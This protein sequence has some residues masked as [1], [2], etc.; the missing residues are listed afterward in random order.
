MERNR[1][2]MNLSQVSCTAIMTLINRVVASDMKNAAFSDPMAA[3]CLGRLTLL[4]SAEERSWILRTKRLL[5]GI[6]AHHVKEVVRRVSFFDSSANQFISNHPGCTVVN[7]G[8]GFDTR[9]WRIKTKS[10]HMLKLTSRSARFE[11]RDPEG[12]AAL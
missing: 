8:C 6:Q 5:T 3:L 4:A 9:F 11:T 1:S 7:L 12:S 10:A 2:M